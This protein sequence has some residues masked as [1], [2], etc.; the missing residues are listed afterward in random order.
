MTVTVTYLV[1]PQEFLIKVNGLKPSTT[2]YFYFDTIKQS[3]SKMKPNG[4]SK[5]DS[6]V[7]DSNGYLEF[8]YFFDGDAPEASSTL[9]DALKA[10]ALSIGPKSYTITSYDFG[11]SLPN[12]YYDRSGSYATNTLEIAT[13]TIL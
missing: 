4:K 11:S 13:E 9:E 5:G 12:D 2:H 10:N 7:S 6:L 8:T 1:R 3:A